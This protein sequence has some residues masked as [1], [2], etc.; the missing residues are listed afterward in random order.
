MD[1]RELF[2]QYVE[3]IGAAKD[4]DRNKVDQRQDKERDLFLNALEKDCNIPVNEREQHSVKRI[5][6]SRNA[7]FPIDE[8]LDLHGL[9]LR[10]AIT[11]LTS[12]IASCHRENLHTVLVI[13]GKGKRSPSG[14]ILKPGVENWIT[15][16]GSA[17][18]S[19]YGNASRFQGGSGAF[20]IYLRKRAGRLL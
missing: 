1:D 6:I 7:N 15:R 9:T 20:V 4:V 16:E 14:A 3:T 12:F 19:S 17:W 10:E 13:T 2:L 18:I 11:S 8:T 5:A